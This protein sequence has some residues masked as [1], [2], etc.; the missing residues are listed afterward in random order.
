MRAQLFAKLKK[1][2][3]LAV[4]YNLEAAIRGRHRLM[5]RRRQI[6]N[7][8]PVVRESRHSRPVDENSGIVR[9]AVVLRGYHA[10]KLRTVPAWSE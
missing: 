9:P 10:L 1:I 4:E 7:A 6:E 5:A 2:I 3:D 8:E